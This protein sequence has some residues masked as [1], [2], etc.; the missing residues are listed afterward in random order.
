MNFCEEFIPWELLRGKH[1]LI[2]GASGLI[3]GRLVEFLLAAS[4]RLSLGIDVTAIVRDYEKAMARFKFYREE[5]NFEIIATDITE[6]I[7]SSG[8]IDYIVHGAGVTGNPKLFVEKPVEV[9]NTA[10]EGTKCVL[11]IARERKSAGVV[12]LSS[13]EAYGTPPDCLISESN[14]GGA[15]LEDVRTSYKESKRLGEQ[16]CVAYAHEFGVPTKVARISITSGPGF[17]EKD[18]RFLPQFIRMAAAGRDIVLKTAGGTVRSHVFLDDCVSAI[19]TI[20]LK[21]SVGMAYNIANRECAFSVAEIAGMI[22]D[23]AGVRVVF[24]SATDIAH[25]GYNKTIKAVLDPSRLEA[26]G[27]RPKV[28]MK[29]M[30]IRMLE[31]VK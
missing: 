7:P 18:M 14:Y 1:V 19:L 6:E 4:K 13:W 25:L 12:F 21:G 27:W 30:L 28:G 23:A 5:Q 26:L 8:P 22:A 16:L 9:L 10:F 20:L 2:T 29:D 24:D 11:E 31:G 15:D 17:S 3:G